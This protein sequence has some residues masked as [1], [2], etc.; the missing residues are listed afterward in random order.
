ML[1]VYIY[2]VYVKSCRTVHKV[3]L[4]LAK[5]EALAK[6]IINVW[7]N[8]AMFVKDRKANVYHDIFEIKNSIS[9]TLRTLYSHER[10]YSITI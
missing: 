6:F 10:N 9:L 1:K 7:K 2:N 8:S 3:M 4:S 5:N